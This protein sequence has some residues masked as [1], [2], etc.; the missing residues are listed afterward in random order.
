VARP[1]RGLSGINRNLACCSDSAIRIS[2]GRAAG[3]DARAAVTAQ[4]AD[5]VDSDLLRDVHLLVSEVVNNSVVHGGVDE[6]G[7]IEI[8]LNAD[9][10][11]LRC[12]VRDSGSDGE[13]TPRDPDFE[14][15]GGFGLFL[16]EAMAARWGSDRDTHLT[17]WFEL[18]LAG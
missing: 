3:G 13:P 4:L 5:D 2:G 17:V 14:N 8:A 12:E 1:A 6:D 11:R 9:G 16:V 15:G 7:W 10:D 18:D